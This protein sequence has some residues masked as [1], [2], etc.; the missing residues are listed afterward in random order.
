MILTL[1]LQTAAA[2]SFTADV[3]VLSASGVNAAGLWSPVS[4][5]TIGSPAVFRDE[6]NAL[7]FMFYETQLG[8]PT[9]ACPAGEWGIGLAIFQSSIFGG[10]WEDLGPVITPTPGTYYSCVAAH[11]T[12]VNLGP[13]A[14][15]QWVVY[16]K[17]ELDVASCIPNSDYDCERYP[18]FGRFV[19]EDGNFA[20]STLPTGGGN[21]GIYR[22]TPPDPSPVLE[23]LPDESGYP[24]AVFADGQYRF[25]YAEKPD[26]YS[27]SG[28]FSSGLGPN[29]DFPSPTGPTVL[30]SSTGSGWA[31]SEMFSPGLLCTGSS[32]AMPSTLAYDMYIGG[33]VFA[34]YPTI[35]DS[36]MG[37]YEATSFTGPWAEDPSSPLLSVSL[38][39]NE[40]RHLD[41]Q[42]DGGGLVAIYYSTPNGSGGNDIRRTNEAGFAAGNLIAKRCP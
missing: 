12:V 8:P 42:R 6:I 18:G 4:I 5:T 27:T 11:P 36:S 9:T 30:A 28:P 7:L 15:Q 14:N 37:L 32:T 25:V 29:T 35:A 3:P 10:S 39:D 2:Q 40:I 26:V 23:D 21:I 20:A 22:Y 33:R 41:P 31:E 13:P 38:G 24:S 34:S 19:F 16:F 17:A 1:L